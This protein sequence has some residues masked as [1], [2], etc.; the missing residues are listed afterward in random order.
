MH[1]NPYGEDVVNLAADLANRRPANAEELAD[2]CRAAGL[3]LEHPVTAQDVERTH[4]VLDAWEK[5]V[6]ADDE[7]ERAEL[8]N[9]MLAAA[10]AHPRLTD[11][12]DGGWHLHYRDDRQPLGALLFSL[13][14]VGT[15]LHLAGRGMRRLGRCAVTECTVIFADTSRTGRQRYCSQRCANRD[16]VRRHRALR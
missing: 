3:V 10:A 1:L 4:E 14:S 2:R 5:V 15:A 7:R 8:L 12:A 16:A 6:D 11:H 9:R 13:I